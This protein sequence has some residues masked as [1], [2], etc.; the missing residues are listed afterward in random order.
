MASFLKAFDH[1]TMPKKIS[2]QDLISF[3]K[4]QDS[5]VKIDLFYRLDKIK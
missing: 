5:C 3:M 2:L 1:Q 4:K